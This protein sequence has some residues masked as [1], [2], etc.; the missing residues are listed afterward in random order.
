MVTAR[1][2]KKSQMLREAEGYLELLL[3][4]SPLRLSLEIRTP[5]AER[6]LQLLDQAQ[7][8]EMWAPHSLY[9]RG[10]ALRLM[11]RYAE[12][13]VPFRRAA[14]L[15]PGDERLWLSLGWCYKR[16]RRIDLA[17]ECLEEAL[18]L[19]PHRA[20]LHYNLACYWSLA[21]N[22][23]AAVA[24]LARAVELDPRYRERAFSEPDFDPIRSHPAFQ[25]ITTVIV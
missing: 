16:C 6:A 22:V 9:L 8:A 19:A 13:V 18:A 25:S 21:R 12:A 7:I 20:I 15:S 10:Q 11:E 1:Q 4:A 23:L 3:A 24:S 17:I 14:E 2:L 5:L